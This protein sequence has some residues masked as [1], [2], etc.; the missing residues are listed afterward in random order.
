ME[1]FEEIILKSNNNKKNN[2]RRSNNV[3]KVIINKHKKDLEDVIEKYL[4]KDYEEN[5][6]R[7]L[8]KKESILEKS[9]YKRLINGIDKD[10][11]RQL[12]TADKQ[13]KEVNRYLD[14][15]GSKNNNNKEIYLPGISNLTKISSFDL[16]D[17]LGFTKDEVKRQKYSEF[18]LDM[19]SKMI[20]IKWEDLE[21]EV[22]NYNPESLNKDSILYNLPVFTQIAKQISSGK[23]NFDEIGKKMQD[24][25]QKNNKGKSKGKKSGKKKKKRG[26]SDQ[27]AAANILEKLMSKKNKKKKNDKGK[28]SGYKNLIEDFLKLYNNAKDKKYNYETF[29]TEIIES[30][31]SKGK[32]PYTGE[33]N[34]QYNNASIKKNQIVK[35]YKEKFNPSKLPNI[36]GNAKEV[37]N[38]KIKYATGILIYLVAI[39]K[40]LISIIDWL[41]NKLSNSNNNLRNSNSNNTRNSN[42]KN[43]RN[44]NLNNSNNKENNTN[45]RNE[46][47][48]YKNLLKKIYQQLDKAKASKQKEL[49]IEL[50]K[51][52]KD[53]KKELNS[54]IN[55]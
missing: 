16:P 26:G 43:T 17:I 12:E 36:L 52:K 30:S 22:N 1:N 3:K 5:L 50:E 37:K 14:I 35:D 24:E 11:K 39:Q 13:I 38:I 29:K 48:K 8:E 33:E 40:I 28:S 25:K 10:L 42:S 47:R 15:E 53:T 46:I 4:Q 9:D 45:S 41:K 55:E 18:I 31:L 7:T 32:N 44:N 27:A 23:I 54:L 19:V 51:L 21:D 49:I 34:K 6:K 20:D 2:S